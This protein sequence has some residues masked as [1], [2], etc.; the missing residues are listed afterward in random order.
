MSKPFYA[1]YV[2]LRT[3]SYMRPDIFQDKSEAI[4]FASKLREFK[5]P[6]KE[7][8]VHIYEVKDLEF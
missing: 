1:V 2:K 8:S 6:T 5:E 4:E 3:G 7:K